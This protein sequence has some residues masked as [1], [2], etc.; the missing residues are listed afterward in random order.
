MLPGESAQLQIQVTILNLVDSQDNGLGIFDN[1]VILTGASTNGNTF[2][3][4]STDGIDPGPGGGG[5][6]TTIVLAQAEVCGT[7]YVVSDSDGVF[8]AN[9]EGILG[10]EI[11]LSGTDI[12]GELVTATTFTD[13]DGFYSFPDLLPGTYTVTEI[14]PTQLIDGPD[15]IG[16]LGGDASVNDQF[17]IVIPAGDTTGSKENNF[18]EIGVSGGVISKA[19]LLASTPSDY[20]EGLAVS[21]SEALWVPFEAQ[22]SGAVQAL[23]IETETI[24][25]E[26]FDANMQSLNLSLIHI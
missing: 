8:G 24:D 23:L 6:P 18:S 16:T 10:V 1:E 20:W 26:L 21:G 12:F 14:Q 11:M 4:P 19:L 25:V 3:D 2:S 22:S 15:Q 9:D 5:S 7:V 13:L 17:T